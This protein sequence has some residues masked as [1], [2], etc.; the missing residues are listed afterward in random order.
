MAEFWNPTGGRQLPT[1]VRE[2][3]LD[4]AVVGVVDQFRGPVQYVAAQRCL[5]LRVAIPD[6]LQLITGTDELAEHRNQ[7]AGRYG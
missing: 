1:D 7:L 5:C 4:I 2:P 3:C 6:L